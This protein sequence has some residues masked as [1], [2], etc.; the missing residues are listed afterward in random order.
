M[1]AYSYEDIIEMEQKRQD[2]NV[3]LIASENFPSKRVLNACG[4]ILTN[5]YAE[6]YSGKRYYGGCQYIDM[7]EQKAIS[8]ACTLFNC[9]YANVQPH[10]GS[11]ANQAVYRALL[12]HGDTVLGMDLG[13]GGHLTHGHKMSF[14]GQDYKIV[15]YGVT[16]DGI[17]DYQDIED[18]LYNCNPRMLLVG[19]SSYSQIID[20]ERI[21]HILDVYNGSIMV[22][23]EKQFS[24][25]DVE[26]YYNESKC[27]FMVD[28]AHVAGLVAGGVHPNPC[29]YADVI[30][31]TTH[32]TLRGPRGGII[33]WNDE[34]LT[35]A[36]NSA[37]FPGIQGGPL[38]HIIC[39]KGICFEEAMTEEFKDY[40]KQVVKNA[41]VFADKFIELGWKVISN[42]TE[43]H[44]FVLDV[45][46]SIGLTGKQAEEIL[47]EVNIT[48][49]KNQI[50]NDELPP[51]KSSGIRIGTPAMTTKGWK[52]EDFIKLAEL[53]NHILKS[54]KDIV[55]DEDISN[56]VIKEKYG[57]DV[58]ELVH[59]R[60]DII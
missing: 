25:D 37:V 17:I 44:M 2:D 6:G 33:L 27:Y 24:K 58:Y 7:I 28:M 23:L 14:S 10:C 50:P 19:A 51:M 36:I 35:K 49:N 54:Y 11:S 18:K 31:S 43:N 13:A 60:R 5:K 21:K 59:K 47:D 30:T 57:S 16:S 12:K 34:K 42:G 39:A 56:S 20:Y 45:Y 26:K 53:I 1:N 22:E 55:D 15:S 40:A 3:E 52:E 8:D 41:K 38:E 9:N 48:V 4:S 32:K 29:K 46:N